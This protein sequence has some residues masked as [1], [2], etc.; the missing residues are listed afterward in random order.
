MLG[1]MDDLKISHAR[2]DVVSGV[3]D[4]YPRGMVRRCL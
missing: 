2:K 3:I 1:R 4:I